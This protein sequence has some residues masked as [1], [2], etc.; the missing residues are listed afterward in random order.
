MLRLVSSSWT[1]SLIGE[2]EC[3]ARSFVITQDSDQP[4]EREA[5]KRTVTPSVRPTFLQAGQPKLAELQLEAQR[6]K[7]P[8]GI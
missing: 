7:P 6:E 4:S 3:Q 2:A 8:H 5:S 1:V